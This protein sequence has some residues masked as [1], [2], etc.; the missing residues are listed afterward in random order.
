MPRQTQFPSPSR[1][2]CLSQIH[3]CSA[4]YFALWTIVPVE[5]DQRMNSQLELSPNLL[6][7]LPLT[8]QFFSE[9]GIASYIFTYVCCNTNSVYTGQNKES[10]EKCLL[11]APLAF[12]PAFFMNCICRSPH[13]CHVMESSCSYI[14]LLLLLKVT[15]KLFKASALSDLLLAP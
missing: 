1:G 15:I 3:R 13:S 14:F 6:K 5:S 8:C 7:P 9:A 11:L 10:W 2:T 4:E 12:A